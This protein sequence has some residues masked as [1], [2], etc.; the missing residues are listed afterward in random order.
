MVDIDSLLHH[1]RYVIQ[2]A[3]HI[4]NAGV[5]CFIVAFILL[6]RASHVFKFTFLPFEFVIF[7]SILTDLY[8]L[9]M[10]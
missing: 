1:S 2:I 8:S 6:L 7:I 4:R 5:Q 9:D 3:T 10:H